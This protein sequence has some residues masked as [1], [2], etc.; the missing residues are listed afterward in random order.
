MDWSNLR[1]QTNVS[2]YSFRAWISPTQM[3]M[4]RYYLAHF[5]FYWRA[6][7]NPLSITLIC[8]LSTLK[9]HLSASNCDTPFWCSSTCP[10]P[11]TLSSIPALRD[12]PSLN[13]ML[14]T[15]YV[16]KMYSMYP[17]LCFFSVIR[18]TMLMPCGLLKDPAFF[19]IVAYVILFSKVRRII[20][21]A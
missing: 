16:L 3:T 9:A 4:N 18:N 12:N 10:P 13:R 5:P 7:S 6:Y 8:D 21:T 19:L 11:C 1:Y 14:L 17:Q 15:T 20:F 2:I